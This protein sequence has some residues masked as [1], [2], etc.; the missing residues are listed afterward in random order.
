[1]GHAQGH[2]AGADAPFVDEMHIQAIHRC[3]IMVPAIELGLLGAPIEV[4]APVVD[5]VFEILQIA[6]IVPPRA[7]NRIG[8]TGLAQTLAQ[9]VQDIVW[10]VDRER[11]H[12]HDGS[13]HG[14]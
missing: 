3:L 4:R 5:Q 9:V 8:K 14:C 6:V 1:V 7:R 12:L 10:D 2:G 11:P 13:S